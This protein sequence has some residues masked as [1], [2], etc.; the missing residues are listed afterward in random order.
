MFE[1]EM[2]SI[3]STRIPFTIINIMFRCVDN[4]LSD[5]TAD[6]VIVIAN[7]IRPPINI[8]RT[9]ATPSNPISVLF[10]NTRNI[11]CLL[12]NLIRSRRILIH[13]HF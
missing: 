4:Y 9:I 12:E 7:E 13:L 10:M 6:L 5:L 8:M 11:S 1:I 2:F 3:I